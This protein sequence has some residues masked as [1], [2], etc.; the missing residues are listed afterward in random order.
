ALVQGT[1]EYVNPPQTP[2]TYSAAGAAF[3]F[4][5]LKGHMRARTASSIT[6]TA[7]TYGSSGVI[8]DAAGG[9]PN[10]SNSYAGCTNWYTS[11]CRTVFT[12]V[13]GGF[14]PVLHYLKSSELGTIGP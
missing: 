3:T 4:P 11:T 13:T 12:T 9:I 2:A 14:N 6:A 1:L 8:F 7:S 10:T 5:A